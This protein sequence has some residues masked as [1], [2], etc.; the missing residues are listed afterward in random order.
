MS[1]FVQLVSY[2]GFDI[3]PTVLDCMN[4]ASDKGGLR[5]G[6]VLQQ[7]EEVPADLNRPGTTVQRVSLEASLGHGWARRMSQS[8]YSSED[9]TLQVDS[10]SRFAEGWDSNLIAAL[11]KTGRERPMITNCPNKFNLSN[12]EMEVPGVAYRLQPQ[13]FFNS[14]PTCWAAP[15]KGLKEIIPARIVN[16]NFFFTVGRHCSECPHDPSLYWSEL[17]SFLTLNSFTRGY[18]LFHHFEPIVWMDYSKR[19]R[20]WED[21]KDWW[22]RSHESSIRLSDLA[23]GRASGLGQARSVLDYQ[24][25]SGL[26][27]VGRRIHREV[28]AGKNPPFE[29][30]DDRSWEAAMG[31]DYSI[32]VCWNPDEIERCEDYDYWYFALEDANGGVLIRHDLRVER[33]APTMNFKVNQRK[34]FFKSFDGK[35]PAKLCIW[36]VSKSKGWLKKSYFPLDSS[37]I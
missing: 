7:D 36:P 20:H 27:F 31:K 10:G 25:Y 3:V 6:I 11:S 35:E 15:M 9:Y 5:F 17:D 14:F 18:D 23:S 12:G 4:K 2:R 22:V 24:R 16:D 21:H 30:T 32:T 1:V 13:N 33:D 8:M 34:V 29:Y 37:V 28:L 26:D 19:P